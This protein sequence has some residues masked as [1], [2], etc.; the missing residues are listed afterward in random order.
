MLRSSSYSR[1][2]IG[3]LMI[4]ALS[5]SL[6]QLALR[7]LL[8]ECKNLCRG[9]PWFQVYQ[10]F[11]YCTRLGLSPLWND[12]SLSGL[13]GAAHPVA[14]SPSPSKVAKVAPRMNKFLA[15]TPFGRLA[16]PTR[17]PI[18]CETKWVA[19]KPPALVHLCQRGSYHTIA[20]IGF[21]SFPT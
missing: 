12:F 7:C 19:R 2:S 3:W 10:R 14:S 16:T 17:E 21:Q 9:S 20:H 1:C 6:S 4:L 11:P 8:K 13:C 5:H 18:H 15:L